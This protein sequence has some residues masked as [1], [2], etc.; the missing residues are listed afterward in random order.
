MLVLESTRQR[1]NSPSLW[2]TGRVR[3]FGTKGVLPRQ[4]AGGRKT[5]HRSVLQQERPAPAPLAPASAKAITMITANFHGIFF[6]SLLAACDLYLLS[7]PQLYDDE[8]HHPGLL[9]LFRREEAKGGAKDG[10]TR[11]QNTFWSQR[12]PAGGP[13]P[14][15]FAEKAAA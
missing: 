3:V 4:C 2:P 7:P 10:H 1:T 15:P 14:L 9:R 8:D 11:T 12:S 13:C 5:V 6:L